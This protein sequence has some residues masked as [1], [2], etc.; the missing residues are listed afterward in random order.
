MSACNICGNSNNNKSHIAKEM[1]LGFRDEHEYLEC[2]DCGCLQ[3]VNIPEN[4]PDYYP[5][6][7]YYSYA[8]IQSGNPLK[9][10]L[11]SH[12]DYYEATGEGLIGKLIANFNPQ[13]KLQTLRQAGINKDSSILDV[14]CGAG[15]LLYS[16]KEAGFKNL[17]GVDPFN[18]GDIEYKN[19]LNIEK[20]A[21]TEVEGSWDLITFNHSFEHIA[22]QLEVIQKASDLL[23]PNGTCLIRVPTVSS[24]AWGKYGVNWVQLD[25]PRH[26]YLHS[27]ESM[28]RLADQAGLTLEHH[29]YDSFG[30]HL[31]G[32]EQYVKDIALNDENSYAKNPDKSPFS[33]EQ[34]KAFE[35]QAKQLNKDN[36]GD[37]VAFYLKKKA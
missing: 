7:D 10:F 17:L 37:Q 34:I 22:N 3:I 2:G 24:Y 18:E 20:K 23:A 30:F 19:G 15:H 5:N 29:L 4:L 6:E 21:I 9:Q 32:S 35:Q 31:W 13:T 26:L 28:K 16:L 1:M 36:A 27:I 11:V 14:G 8:N 12:R 33:S 25:A